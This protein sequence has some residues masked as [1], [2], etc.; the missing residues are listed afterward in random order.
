MNCSGS[1]PNGKPKP[2]GMPLMGSIVRPPL[3]YDGDVTDPA[4]LSER[5]FVRITSAPISVDEALSFVA[6]PGAGGTAVFSGPCVTT[7]APAT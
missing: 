2:G 1:S 3:R 7:R 6:D 5:T 4:P